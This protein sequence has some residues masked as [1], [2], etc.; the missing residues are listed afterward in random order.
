MNAI[1][2]VVRSNCDALGRAFRSEQ[3]L[4]P[5]SSG[6]SHILKFQS[7]LKLFGINPQDT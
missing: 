1:A 5:L 2:V 7:Y 6:L 3:H 4:Q